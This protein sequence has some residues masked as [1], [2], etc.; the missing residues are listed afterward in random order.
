MKY[1]YKPTKYILKEDFR[2]AIPWLRIKYDNGLLCAD[3]GLLIIRKGYSW[4][5][6][7]GIALDTEDFMTPSL[8]HDALYQLIREK[9]LPLE[10][11]D[12]ADHLMYRLC[13]HNG[14]WKFRAKYCLWAVRRFAE[15]AA[16]ISHEVRE[17]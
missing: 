1:I 14:M 2:I 17:V 13:I 8:V 6:P 11:R 7:S 3:D 5:G 9:A 16:K 15:K 12:E 4:D 10:F